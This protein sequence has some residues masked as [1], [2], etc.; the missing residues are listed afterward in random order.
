LSPAKNLCY[1]LLHA[2]QF[3]FFVATTATPTTGGRFCAFIKEANP[4]TDPLL[5]PTGFLFFAARFFMSG[6]LV[7][8]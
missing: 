5:N 8:F 2:F 4:N 3:D 1:I 6:F 7:I